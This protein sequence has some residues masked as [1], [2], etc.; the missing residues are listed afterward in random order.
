[1]SEHCAGILCLHMEWKSTIEVQRM[2]Q[3]IWLRKKSRAYL[4]LVLKT[5]H[6]S[7]VHRLNLGC[8]LEKIKGLLT[9]SLITK[10]LPFLVQPW[11]N[12]LVNT[13]FCVPL[14]SFI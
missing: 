11:T 14:K 4:H 3:I 7:K 9:N 13:L 2:K 12:S 5:Q 6:H 8:L 10:S 1:M